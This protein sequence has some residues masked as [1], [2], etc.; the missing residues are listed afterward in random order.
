MGNLQ[1][2]MEAGEAVTVRFTQR[3]LYEAVELPLGYQFSVLS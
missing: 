2:T 3:L 1:K